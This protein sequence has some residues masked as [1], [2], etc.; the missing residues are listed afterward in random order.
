MSGSPDIEDF[1]RTL[2]EAGRQISRELQEAEKVRSDPEK[3]VQDRERTVAEA[4][5]NAKH[6]YK[7]KE[8]GRAFTEWERA[9]SAMGSP[10]EFRRKVRA[11]RE[12]HENLVKVTRELAEIRDVLNQRTA[13]PPA[14][15]KLVDGA[16]E[17]VTGQVKDVYASLSQRLRGA[18]TPRTPNL[19]LPIGVSVLILATGFAAQR[20]YSTRPAPPVAAVSGAPSI[21]DDTFLQAQQNAMEKQVAALNKDHESKIEELRRTH[22]Q[23]SQ[24]DREKIVQL[25]T[26]LKEAEAKQGELERQVEALLKDNLT[27]DDVIASLS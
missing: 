9:C 16:H 12:S 20:V 18:R 13:P 10:E 5:E 11:L 14:D 25:E 24:G 17:S 4:L 6:F 23:A 27:K 26:R 7:R 2:E 19:W 8:Y 22:A 15:V 1:Q 21:T 3:T